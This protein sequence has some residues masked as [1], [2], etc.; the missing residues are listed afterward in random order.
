M[1]CF[2]NPDEPN[3]FLANWYY[4]DFIASGIK[5]NSVEQYMMYNKAMIFE[6]KDTAQKILN[7]RD[8][9]YM[10]KLG[11][12][13]AGYNDNIWST[14]RYNIVKHGVL[15]KFTQNRELAQM[16]LNTEDAILAEC[17]VRDKIWGIGLSMTDPRRLDQSQWRG[18][19]YLGQILMEVREQ[20]RQ[21]NLGCD[22]NN[23]TFQWEG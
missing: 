1:V 10:K 4:S 13:V 15:N 2:H 23:M 11:R 5:F 16:L 18:T 7:T 12:E 21:I 19:N 17:A 3:A 14:H 8:F 9:A 6:D 22:T 20:L